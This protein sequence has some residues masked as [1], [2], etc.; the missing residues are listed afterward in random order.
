MTMSHTEI[1][2]RGK[3]V[4]VPSAQIDGRT[5]ITTGKWLKIVAV[6]DEEL[7]EAETVPNPD[8]FIAQLKERGPNADIFTF[9][10]KLPHTTP[11]HEYHLEWDNVA[12]IPITTYSEWW[13]KR[14]ES[15]R[16]KS[17]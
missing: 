1:A 8:A 5:V 3:V 12:V 7:V 6:Q 15:R 10:Q 17:R 2:I 13:D 16:T 9:A 4:R 11:K 14:A